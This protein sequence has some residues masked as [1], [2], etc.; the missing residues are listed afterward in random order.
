MSGKRKNT[1]QAARKY[2]YSRHPNGFGISP[3][4]F[5]AASDET[6][7]SFDDLIHF[8][9]RLYAGGAQTSTFRQDDLSHA[10]AGV[11]T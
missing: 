11:N 3:Q 4:K 2:L 6:G 1:V 7:Q 8:I 10:V 9:S 5:A